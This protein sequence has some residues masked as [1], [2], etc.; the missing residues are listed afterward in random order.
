MEESHKSDPEESPAAE[1]H[2]TVEQGPNVEITIN[3]ARKLIHRGRQT[4]VEI[5]NVGGVPLAD[6]LEQLIDGRLIPLRDDASVT[7]KGGEIFMSHV[8]TGDSA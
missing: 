5:K 3:N 8:R 6:E 2:G 1:K 4:V 7:I